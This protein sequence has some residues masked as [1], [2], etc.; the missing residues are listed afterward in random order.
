MMPYIPSEAEKAT[1][2]LR[3]LYQA[4]HKKNV[5]LTAKVK[6]LEREVAWHESQKKG[7]K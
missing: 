5:A 3:E 4:E 1:T 7:A 2:V 6:E